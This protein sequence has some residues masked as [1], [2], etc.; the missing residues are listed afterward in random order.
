MEGASLVE[1]ATDT[2]NASAG[3]A[4][5]ASAGNTHPAHKPKATLN[6]IALP[7]L[8]VSFTVISHASTG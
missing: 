6:L 5:D 2:R 4:S 1:A 3:G 7:L 8:T